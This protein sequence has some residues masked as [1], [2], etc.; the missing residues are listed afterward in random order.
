MGISAARSGAK[1]LH[2]AA[3]V[4]DIMPIVS[5]TSVSQGDAEATTSATLTAS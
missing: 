4:A 5:S 1:G 2:S 3:R